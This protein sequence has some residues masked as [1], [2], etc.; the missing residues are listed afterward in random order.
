MYKI[1]TKEMGVP[2]RYVHKILL[3][4]RLT[5]VIFIA[6]LMQV[7]AAGF[8]QKISLSKTNAP[9]KSILKEL[10]LQSG[11]DFVFTEQMLQN[12]KPVDI[13]VNHADIDEVLQSIFSKQPLDYHIREKTVVITVKEPSI[14]NRIVS[15]FTDIS[16]SGKVL[17]ERGQPLSDVTVSIKGIDRKTSTDKNGIF[18]IKAEN[19]NDI[20]VFRSVGMETVEI[21]LDSRTSLI[22][23]LKPKDNAL[24]E[25]TIN[26][27]FQKIKKEQMTG[28]TVTVNSEELEK[29]YQPNIINNL[30]GRIPGLV[31]YRGATT[32]RGVS[33]I[34]SSTAQLIVVDGLP[35]EGSIA[36]INPYD[37][38][39]I[40]VL[41]DAAAAAIYGIRAANGVIV[42][43]TKRAKN[44]RTSVEF[45]TDITITQKPDIGFQMLTPDQQVDLESNFFNYQ[46]LTGTATTTNLNKT[47]A[48]INSGNSITPVQYAYYQRAKGLISQTQ[49]ESQLSGFKQNDFRKQFT[50][51]ALLNDILQQYNLAIRTDGNKYQS[52]LVLNYKTDNTGIVNAYNNQLNIFYK[53]TYNFGKWLDVNFGVNG[54][55]GRS[56]ASNSSFAT[57]GTNVSPYL[58]L[59]NGDGSR[60][61]YT[62]ADYNMYNTNPASSPRYSMLANHLDELGL[63]S[64]NTKQTNT[65]YYVNAVARILPGLTFA[66]QFQYE[67]MITDVSSYAEPESY[68]MR[69]LKS[70]YSMPSASAPGGYTSLLPDNGG[71][72]A[73]INSTGD[74]WTARGQLNYRKQFG[75]NSIDVIAGTEFRQ[76]RTKGTGGLLLGYD[77]QLQSQSTTSVS[78]PALFA[79]N[80]SAAFK[81]GFSTSNLYNTY[82]NNPIAVLPETTHR[83]N[84][85]YAN[86]TYT[87]DNK[88]NAFGSYRID[89]ADVFGLDKKFRGSPLWSAGLGWNLSNEAFMSA[90]D[91][92]NFAKLRATYGVTGNVALG[93]TSLLTANSTLTNAATNLPA[94][95]VTSAANPELRWE[96]TATTNLGLDFTLFNN[97]LNGALDWY[98]K[99][100][101]DIF[102][103]KRIDASEG[104]TSQVINNA[105]LVNKG[106]ELSLE[107]RW[108]KPDKRDGIGW[109]SLLVISHNNNRITYVD[110]VSVS[111][112]ALVQG[113]YKV[114]Y[115]VNSLYSFQYKGL[116]SVGQPQWLKADGTLTTVALTNNDLSAV[117]YSGGTD[118]INNI[119]L[120]NEIFYKGFSLNVL[121]VY[122]GGQYLRALV[123][124]IYSGV[125]YASMPS[126][127]LNSWTPAN[128]NTNIPGFGQYAPSVYPGSS[129]VP[130][131]HLPYSDA[132]V[133]AGDFI[134]IRSVVLGYQLPHQWAEKIGTKSVKVHFQL[135]N[136]KAIWVKNDVG[137]DPETGGAPTLTSYVFGAN[138]NF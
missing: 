104:F 44:K 119:A 114:G 70:I 14:L 62:T 138:I 50:D 78:Y 102:F 2:M 117:A 111:P 101:T 28:A 27:G 46:Y 131:N 18:V 51:N 91:W 67:N 24:E 29:R 80:L 55:I 45:S 113:G 134:K 76:T 49:L 4:M 43:T 64:R 121:A 37:V 9:L 13:K 120:T 30:E 86:A 81:P 47:A 128:T 59:L 17:D 105:S 56:K 12:A 60:A 82:L 136:P 66:P 21:G 85:G 52:S 99:K 116:N 34:Q 1:C 48:D 11:Y 40:T 135:N 39:S 110:E 54:V 32:I 130:A 25:V 74:A 125:P 94:S 133:R 19:A 92:V 63:D 106:I 26:T 36:D 57:S 77:D 93:V 90:F 16:V 72:L 89:Y 73:T 20:L 65:R 96:K 88:Y 35:I 129:A 137:I 109:S 15:A 42:I 87:Y 33:T 112:I 31:N 122:Y 58:Q 10:R 84:S 22:I 23:H 118:P 6:T 95:V 75:K 97:R 132:F 124:D 68:V 83:F 5:T 69:Y 115:P 79:Y 126:Y 7:S 41:K 61:Y 103:S 100:G 127:L 8:A 71:K 107:Y 38:E 53:G 123:P 98:R 3:I 108:L